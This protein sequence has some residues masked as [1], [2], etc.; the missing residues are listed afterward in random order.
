MNKEEP[1]KSENRTDKIGLS[2]AN[3]SNSRPTLSLEPAVK[4]QARA[5]C[6]KVYSLS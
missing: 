3:V 5:T 1:I 2:I 4:H 6:S